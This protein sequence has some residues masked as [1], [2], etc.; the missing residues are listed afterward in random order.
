M[1]CASE[2]DHKFRFTH[3]DRVGQAWEV[4]LKCGKINRR[5]K[6]TK[7][8]V[9]REKVSLTLKEKR[10][11]AARLERAEKNFDPRAAR[12]TAN[13]LVARF[14]ARYAERHAQ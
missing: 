10:V 2:L 6:L 8:S 5:D 4:C 1:A 13:E 3:R 11:A 9:E 12:V 7:R 14:E